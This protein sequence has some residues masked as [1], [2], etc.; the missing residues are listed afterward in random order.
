MDTGNCEDCK[1]WKMAA[2]LIAADVAFYSTY[3]EETDSHDGLTFCLLMNDVWMWASAD[4]EAIPFETIPEVYKIWK[5]APD[6][7]SEYV[8]IQWASEK[9][10]QSPQEPMLKQMVNDGFDISWID[11]L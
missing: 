5:E 8:L 2:E 1:I 11:N 7:Q 9:R 3:N 10:K 4:A 6:K